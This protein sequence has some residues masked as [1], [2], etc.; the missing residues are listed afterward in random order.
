[1][2]SVSDLSVQ[3]WNLDLPMNSKHHPKRPI[4]KTDVLFQRADS[5][6]EKGN[7]LSA[8]RLFLTAAKMGDPGCQVN[9]GYISDTSLGVKRNRNAALYWYR[10]AF[11]QGDHCGANNIGTIYRDEGEMDRAMLWFRRAVTLGDG[12]ANLEIAKIYLRD[13]KDSKKA[14][15][16]LMKTCNAKFVTELVARKSPTNT[17]AASKASLAADGLLNS[18]NC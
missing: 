13:K 9:L 4:R 12:D 3:S 14:I 17:E 5:Q 6:Q 2:S 8:F 10:R 7:L 16:Y 1:M 15:H 11:R 18:I